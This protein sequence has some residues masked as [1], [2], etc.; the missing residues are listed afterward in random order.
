MCVVVMSLSCDFT[1]SYIDGLPTWCS[2][3]SMKCCVSQRWICF[4][5]VGNYRKNVGD[6]VSIHYLYLCVGLGLFCHSD[7]WVLDVSVYGYWGIFHFLNIL[8]LEVIFVVRLIRLLGGS[9]GG[10]FLELFYPCLNCCMP[11]FFISLLL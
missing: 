2:P 5:P 9:T 7:V 6:L 1:F 11:L 3:T 10:F 4:K 8:H